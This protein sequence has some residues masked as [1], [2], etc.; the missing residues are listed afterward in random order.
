MGSEEGGGPALGV[1]RR[2]GGCHGES[3]SG[4]QAP[5]GPGIHSQPVPRRQLAAILPL[6]APALPASGGS[7]PGRCLCCSHASDGH[8]AHPWS[9]PN[10]VLVSLLV[11]TDCG[12]T[13]KA[14]R[15]QP[16]S[17]W[18]PVPCGQVSCPVRSLLWASSIVGSSDSACVMSCHLSQMHCLSLR[19]ASA[20]GAA[21]TDRAAGT[22]VQFQP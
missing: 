8:R 4:W 5:L 12:P 17:A 2:S 13:F 22:G 15:V 20:G 6:L 1:R 11:V 14:T 7:F 3:L 10:P 18:Q 19:T 16:S 9:R 21:N